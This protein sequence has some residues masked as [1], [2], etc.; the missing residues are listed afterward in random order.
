MKLSIV[1]F[2]GSAIND[3]TAFQASFNKDMPGLPSSTPVTVARPNDFP[4]DTLTSTYE[5]AFFPVIVRMMGTA[6]T[7]S[8]TL[9]GLFDT[10]NTT[11]GTLL[12][13]DTNNG[14]KQLYMMAR[15]ISQPEK[16]GPVVTFNMFASD[17]IWRAGTETAGTVTYSGS[18]TITCVTTGNYSAR[19]RIQITPTASKTGDYAY[20]RRVIVYN[21]STTA[22]FSNYPLNLG[23]LGGTGTFDTATLVSGGKML[24]SGDDCI[25]RVDGVDAP[26]WFN[27]MNS[28]TTSAWINMDL[29]R[30]VT[31]TLNSAMGAGDSVTSIQVKYTKIA[32]SDMLGMS[33]S[34]RL[35][36]DSEMFKYSAVSVD[37]KILKFTGVTRSVDGTSAGS[38]SANAVMYHVPHEV[39]IMYGLSSAGT[40]EQDETRKPCLSLASSTNSSWVWSGV[41]R[42]LNG[43]RTASWSPEVV[44]SK[45]KRSYTYTAGSVDFADP[46]SAMGMRMETWSNGTKPQPEDA[47]MVW[48][49]YHPA[50]VTAVTTTG[51]KK[52]LYTT[53]WPKTVGLQKLNGHD[54]VSLWNEAAPSSAATWGTLSAHSAVSTGGTVPYLKYTMDGDIKAGPNNTT[55][56]Y[57]NF[58]VNSTTFAL[59][60]STPYVNMSTEIINYH[61]DVTVTNTT[62]GDSI[63]LDQIM[64]LNLAFVVD[65]D[66]ETCYLENTTPLMAA[67]TLS[68][69]RK[70]W[71]NLQ[72]GTNILTFA[73]SGTASGGTAT[74]IV[75][76][77]DRWIGD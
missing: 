20:K 22:G 26:R 75:A 10:T 13:Q 27:G 14:N 68:S 49:Y 37:K 66:N 48:T 4:S 42:D 21:R 23:V 61:L 56:D 44:S 53:G 51:N 50:G 54:W 3:G 46:A 45:G 41:F 32:K 40:P 62:T 65:T 1:S 67:R 11:R 55:P 15:P 52:A 17:P 73:E 69:V 19:P 39:W 76:W 8:D 74:A 71:L 2:R 25:V 16:N 12:V 33:A 57:A 6:A 38:H 24:S 59:G 77:R 30:Q 58:E 7:Q 9:H 18:G 70:D 63:A 36:I 35:L 72:P 28:G 47:Q 31:L 5:G 34:G 29:P 43:L 64:A 60:A